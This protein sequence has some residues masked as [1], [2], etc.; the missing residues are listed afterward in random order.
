MNS[1]KQKPLSKS[2]SVKCGYCN[3]VILEQNLTRH[4][5]EIHQR[6]RFAA[7]DTRIT[8]YFGTKSQKRKHPTSPSPP[9]SESEETL[10]DQQHDD[11][12]H[13]SEDLPT[14]MSD[15][16]PTES[17]N[18]EKLDKIISRVK[19]IQLTVKSRKEVNKCTLPPIAK[20][21][22]VAPTDQRM[23]QFQLARSLDDIMD[24]F[25]ELKLCQQPNYGY[26]I[27]KLCCSDEIFAQADASDTLHQTIMV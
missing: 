7:G 4:C 20:P 15:C 12:Q 21:D 25:D 5:L 10:P 27:C 11:S 24:H 19:D 1:K 16:L 13:S 23:N 6:E 26:V 18:N 14:A 17:I 3:S 9:G 2:I 22:D 8:S